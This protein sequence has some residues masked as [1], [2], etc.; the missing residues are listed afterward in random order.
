MRIVP[1]KVYSHVFSGEE[2]VCESTAA[3]SAL[4][5][6]DSDD[7]LSEKLFQKD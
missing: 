7:E 4:P 2:R 5:T 6:A 3:S 1:S